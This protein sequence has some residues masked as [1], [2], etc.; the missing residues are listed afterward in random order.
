MQSN[1]SSR[2]TTA[3]KRTKKNENTKIYMWPSTSSLQVF[4]AVAVAIVAFVFVL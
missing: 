1:K 4:V 2:A 3:M